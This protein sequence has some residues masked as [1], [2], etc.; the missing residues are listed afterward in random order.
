MGSNAISRAKYHSCWL[1]IFSW[2][3]LRLRQREVIG[4][5]L[6]TANLENAG[7]RKYFLWEISSTGKANL[8]HHG[9][10]S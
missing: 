9:S 4:H 1:I 6:R 2:Y 10:P 5:L 7:I 8:H 3:L